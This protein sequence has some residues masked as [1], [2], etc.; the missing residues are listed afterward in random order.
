MLKGNQDF[1][2]WP[3]TIQALAF[4][5]VRGT[6]QGGVSMF[7]KFDKTGKGVRNFTIGNGRFWLLP[8]KAI[9]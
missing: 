9:V 6:M 2:T 8:D 3:D 7:G 1:S 5:L 4:I